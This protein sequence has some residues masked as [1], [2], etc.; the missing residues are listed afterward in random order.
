MNTGTDYH[1]NDDGSLILDEQGNPIPL[2]ICLCA[3]REPY[4]CVCGAWDDVDPN[5]WYRD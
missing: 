2:T 4:E 1:L 3:A 5:E